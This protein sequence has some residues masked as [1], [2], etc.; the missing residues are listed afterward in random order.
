LKLTQLIPVFSEVSKQNFVNEVLLEPWEIETPTD[1]I[2][3]SALKMGVKLDLIGVSRSDSLPGSQCY[4]DPAIQLST[5]YLDIA[6]KLIT[7]DVSHL[8]TSTFFFN[9]TERF[10]HLL[11]LE[12]S[13]P[14]LKLIYKRVRSV[15]SF[16]VTGE[17][18]LEQAS[19]IVALESFTLHEADE[20]IGES[21][22]A[23]QLAEI[24]NEIRFAKGLGYNLKG[25]IKSE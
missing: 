7:I 24:A 21:I 20:V 1:C 12:F 19:V 25:G 17:V 3:T 23:T 8:P 4:L 14:T 18:N 11:K 15:I 13:S 5:V 6:G 16:R 9:T 10:P 2:L 22:T